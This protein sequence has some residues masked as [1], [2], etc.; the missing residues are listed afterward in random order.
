MNTT[1]VQPKAPS[2]KLVLEIS[3]EGHMRFIYD[4][5]LTELL[6]EG[7]ATIERASHVE[8]EGTQ[9]VADMAPMGGPKL[10]PFTKRQDAL[11]AE[12]AWLNENVLGCI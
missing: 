6:D 1:S 3:T 12:V 2:K 11:D 9:W 4:D 8:P 5:V 7:D 10:G